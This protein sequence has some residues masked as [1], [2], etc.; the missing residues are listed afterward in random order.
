MYK[1]YYVM[2]KFNPIMVYSVLTS[3]T[4]SRHFESFPICQKSTFEKVFS[5]DEF[6]K[7][8]ILFVHNEIF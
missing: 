2:V 8:V 3:Q 1:G 6:Y 4:Q 7:P 5:W